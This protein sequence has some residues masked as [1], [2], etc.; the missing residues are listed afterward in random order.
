MKK[1]VIFILSIFVIS[2]NKVVTPPTPPIE[3]SI[4]VFSRARVD[5]TNGVEIKFDLK[6]E[7][8]YT[9]TMK[10]SVTNQVV[11]R[12][13]FKGKVG[14]NKLNIYTKTLNSKYLYLYLEDANRS[15]LG[16]T[17]LNIQ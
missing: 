11:T 16:K 10:D 4:E 12:E 8:T 7:G 2:C 3:T 13:R 9:L 14:I 6:S 17:L 1:L 15:L 5:V